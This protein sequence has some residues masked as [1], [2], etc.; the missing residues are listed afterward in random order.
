MTNYSVW[1]LVQ[2]TNFYLVNVRYQVLVVQFVAVF[3]NTYL[4]WK[5]N[6]PSTDYHMPA[7][8]IE[9]ILLEKN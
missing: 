2:L 3:W 1:P 5:T 7:A 6:K 4:S 9:E 8:N